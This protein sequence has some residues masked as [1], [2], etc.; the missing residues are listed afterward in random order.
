MNRMRR[1]ACVIL[2]AIAAAAPAAAQ[3]PSERAALQ[4]F[5]DTLQVTRD[6][7]TLH[8][9]EAATIV[10]ARLH[11][12]DAL[13]H[14]R[15]GFVALRIFELGGSGSRVE[16]AGSE[17]EWAID[18]QPGWPYPWF[19]LGLAE[20]RTA[21]HA[22]GFAGGLWTMLGVDRET[23]AGN[24]FARAIAADPGFVE[25]LI[26][27]AETA[28]TQRVGAPIGVALDALRLAQV[29]P[30]SWDPGLLLERGRLERLAG[31][32]DSA[33]LAFRRA[34]LLG[35]R[36]ALANLELARTLPL[37]FDTLP[38]Q[39]GAPL[40]V[41]IAYYGA[42][43][44]DDP[45]VVAMFRRDLQPIIDDSILQQFDRVRG[46]A[47]VTWLRNFWQ[48][49][50]ALDMR[51]AGARLSEHFRRWD[52]ANHNF[53]LPPFRRSYRWGIETY[54]SHDTDLD[55]RG[56]V[57]LRQGAP[58]ARVIWP[59]SQPR[60]AGPVRS[61]PVFR[62][63]AQPGTLFINPVVGETPSFGNETWRYARPD[64]DLV[65]NFAAQDDPD[66]YRLVETILQLDVGFDA[67]LEHER[68]LPGLRQL[69]QSG[70]A[71]RVGLA[72]EARLH[73]KKSIATATTT[74]AW[75]RSYPITMGGRAQWLVAGERGGRPL[76]HIVY[77]VDAAMLRRL[78][79]DPLTG[80]VPLRVRAVFVDE[81]GNP[82]A[83]LD[84][85]Q[86]LPRPTTD[87]GFVAARAELPVP[88]GHVTMRLNVEANRAVGTT[89][90]IDS[91][92]APMVHGGSLDLSSIVI[93]VPGRALRWV[94]S[95]ADTAWFAAQSNYTAN[96]TVALFIEAYGVKPGKQY[97]M[98]LSVVREQG[99]IARLL[100]GHKEAV[101]LSEKVSFA[102]DV[103]EIRR[104]LA[105]QGLEPGTYQ[106][107]VRMSADGEVST[108][109]RTLI[110]AR[111]PED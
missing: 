104:S 26:A 31:S 9:M 67:M 108:R 22:S 1:S 4:L 3:S 60:V 78:P 69:L 32:A 94:A 68:E 80:T 15:L 109:R 98:Q 23:R 106:L 28:R 43:V 101:R 88:A 6:T 83:S 102:A 72:N 85:L 92:A 73:G 100:K 46:E 54:H 38:A 34:A 42:A 8:A 39:R 27:F 58:T 99:V 13:L 74:D 35:D 25:G 62:P 76:V 87:V 77:A 75:V 45:E 52:M 96:D 7:L 29:S 107:E 103:G 41:E 84:T 11:R 105:L 50:A 89:Y 81:R 20:A 63:A 95:P 86:R 2:L 24:A 59:T 70:P 19:G 48:R 12:E 82:V 111:P 37:T 30:L 16:D 51:S 5:R 93:G 17:F 65:L 14:I 97:D 36:P 21:D 18:L 66:D 10:Q 90:P 79:G 53:R 64:G 33:R 71:A 55:D 57:W 40:P 44:S 110:I 91:L 47:R 49:R 61:N 56:I